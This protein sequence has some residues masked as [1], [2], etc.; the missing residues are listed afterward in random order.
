MPCEVEVAAYGVQNGR[1]IRVVLDSTRV[2]RSCVYPTIQP[3]YFRSL[4]LRGGM[5]IGPHIHSIVLLRDGR[6]R[7]AHNVLK[8]AFTPIKP[9]VLEQIFR[10]AGPPL[11][12][13]KGISSPT[14]ILQ[15]SGGAL[16]FDPGRWTMSLTKWEREKEKRWE[17][18]E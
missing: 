18:E 12:F 15:I 11:K 17:G 2:S 4:R 1:R 16:R 8:A 9:E 14:S 7:V 6:D 5:D 13:D 3:F 10:D